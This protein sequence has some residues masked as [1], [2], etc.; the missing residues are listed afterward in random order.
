M[1]CL[2]FFLP[3]CAVL[4]F[5]KLFCHPAFWVGIYFLDSLVCTVSS[6]PRLTSSQVPPSARRSHPQT[7]EIA[8]CVF[9]FILTETQTTPTCLSPDLVPPARCELN[10]W[11]KGLLRKPLSFFLTIYIFCF[12]C[13][14]SALL[15]MGLLQSQS[16]AALRCG[17]QASRCSGFSHRRARALEHS[18]A[19]A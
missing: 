12:G 11:G 8:G 3:Y 19:R 18:G 10:F 1:K 15:H 2:G 13:T 7:S 14:G 5:I 9:Q 16:W 17:S 6:G 4:G